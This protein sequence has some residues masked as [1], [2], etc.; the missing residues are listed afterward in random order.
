MQIRA[1]FPISFALSVF[2]LK[3][4]SKGII[5][6]K[7][8]G[9]LKINYLKELPFDTFYSAYGCVKHSGRTGFEN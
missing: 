6:E 9:V 1:E 4:V 7:P 8:L 2:V 5:L 3:N